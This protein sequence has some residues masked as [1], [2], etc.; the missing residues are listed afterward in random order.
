MV[1]EPDKKADIAIAMGGR[2]MLEQQCETEERQGR[3]PKNPIAFYFARARAMELNGGY[4]H[5]LS[6][7]ARDVYTQELQG[8]Y[9]VLFDR[10]MTSN[11]SPF[12]KQELEQ[13]Y[14]FNR[15]FLGFGDTA[16]MNRELED[17]LGRFELL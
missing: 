16:E 9:D 8:V 5:F 2:K 3:V 13:W 1:E 4:L 6:A 10:V 15:D 14:A 12:L 11:I 7:E 17:I